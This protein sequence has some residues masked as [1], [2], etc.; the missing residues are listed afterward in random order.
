MD[1]L[2]VQGKR[3]VLIKAWTTSNFLSDN[4]FS[5]IVKKLILSGVIAFYWKISHKNICFY[6]LKL[7][8]SFVTK[9][10]NTL[11]KLSKANDNFDLKNI[12][13]VHWQICFSLTFN[14]F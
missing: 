5:L 4:L 8:L 9:T 6:A 7:G 10:K 1:V 12:F 13:N 2:D 11:L 14:M 3:E